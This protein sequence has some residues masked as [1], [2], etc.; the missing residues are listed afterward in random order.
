MQRE[1]FE[2]PSFDVGG[3]SGGKATLCRP[4]CR[5]RGSLSSLLW[6]AAGPSGLRPPGVTFS[7][8]C[9][10]RGRCGRWRDRCCCCGPALGLPPEPLACCMLRH[11]AGAE[12][13]CRP[14]PAP[15]VGVGRWGSPRWVFGGGF[16]VLLSGGW[17]LLFYAGGSVCLPLTLREGRC[18]AELSRAVWRWT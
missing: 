12:P 6:R 18:R 8:W 9:E 16:F 14:G 4:N 11:G 7:T 1:G 13:C 15:S 2:F 3:G 10:G 5:S 17:D